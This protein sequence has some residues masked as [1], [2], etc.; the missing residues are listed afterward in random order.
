MAHIWQYPPGTT[1]RQITWVIRFFFLQALTVNLQHK[2]GI[3][4][5]ITALSRYYKKQAERE[6]N[7][8]KCD[9]L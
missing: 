9:T 6:W 7:E 4:E 2:F 8:V 1:S 3:R 5:K